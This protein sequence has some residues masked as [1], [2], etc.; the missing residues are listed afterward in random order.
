MEIAYDILKAAADSV[1]G[2]RED[3]LSP[4][5]SGRGMFNAE[6]VGFSYDY[7]SEL[8]DFLRALEDQGVDIGWMK[9]P[10][11]DSMG[12]GTIAYW[13]NVQATGVPEGVF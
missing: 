4:R 1:G 10:S 5:Y 8:F 2:E 7:D 12:R 11:K 3:A 6:C 13:R 9:N